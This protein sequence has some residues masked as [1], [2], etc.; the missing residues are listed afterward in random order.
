VTTGTA[1]KTMLQLKPTVPCRIVEWGYSLDGFA[2][3]TPGQI[4]LIETGTIFGTVTASAA[5]D[6][7]GQDAEALL[8]GD[9]TSNYI[10]V[11]VSATGYTCTSEG[12]IVAVRNLA[13]PQLVAPTN[14]VIY[15]SPLGFRAFCQ[16]GKATRI[17]MTFGA[18]ISA[19]CYLILDF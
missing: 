13:G 19:Y 14:Q 10:S 15:Q 7:T 1:I 17:R 6:I 9:P 11:G 12:S 16:A 8:F 2:A 4:E 18:A 3:A 5:A